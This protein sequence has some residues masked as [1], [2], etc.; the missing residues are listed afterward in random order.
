MNREFLAIL[1]LATAFLTGCRS[2][3]YYRK[4]AAA[5]AR[6]YA[7]EKLTDLSE[8][9]RDHIRYTPP[10]FLESRVFIREGEKFKSKK[11]IMQTCAVWDVPGLDKSVVVVGVGERSLID[12]NPIRLVRKNFVK[13][14][15]NRQAAV[16]ECVKYVMQN[17][18]YLS[19]AERNRVRFS[20]PKI[21]H[22]DFVFESEEKAKVKL[23]APTQSTMAWSADDPNQK[24]IVIGVG[25][26]NLARWKPVSG[27][28]KDAFIVR[29]HDLSDEKE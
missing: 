18:L 7:L 25:E 1:F 26:P 3:Y 4:Q 21:F 10:Y 17:M 9:K 22:S 5:R 15:E 16:E 20:P 8:V 29:A 11:D 23:D 12:W 14:N 6:D 2:D 24:I 13:P 27:E 28:V 19:N